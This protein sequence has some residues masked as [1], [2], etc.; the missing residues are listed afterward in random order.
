MFIIQDMSLFIKLNI[1]Y[2]CTRQTTQKST[3]ETEGNDGATIRC[4]FRQNK[5][6]PT[7]CHAR[8]RRRDDVNVNTERRRAL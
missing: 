3:S 6:F 2:A 1:I 5:I 7:N 8:L 4:T